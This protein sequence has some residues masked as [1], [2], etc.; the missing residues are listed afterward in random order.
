MLVREDPTAPPPTR[1]T[2]LRPILVAPIALILD[3][4]GLTLALALALALT[5]LLSMA[6][7][8]LLPTRLLHLPLVMSL[9][10]TL[11]L[12]FMQPSL[13]VEIMVFVTS[14]GVPTCATCST[15]VTV[16]DPPFTAGTYTTTVTSN[17]T[18]PV[19]STGT[20]SCATCSVPITVYE[21]PFSAA[22]YTT[23][24]TT[25]MSV[26][27]TTTGTATCATCSIP[28]TVYEPSFTAGTYTTTVTT[29]VTMRMT[30]T[31]TAPCA[32]CSVPVT[33]Y[34]PPTT[35]GTYTTT[36]TADVTAPVTSTGKPSCVTCSTPVT[37]FDPPATTA[38]IFT[39][40]GEQNVTA[41]TTVTK[42]V[43]SS[44]NTVVVQTP[45]CTPGLKWAFY[46][47]TRSP[48]ANTSFPGKIPINTVA[49]DPSSN[50]NSPYGSRYFDVST[51][52][53][54]QSPNVLGTTLL[55]GINARG[56][57]QN[58]PTPLYGDTTV[59]FDRE[60]DVVQQ[61][62]YF[63]PSQSGTYTFNMSSVDD[64]AYLWLG[65][66]AVTGYNN[67]NAAVYSEASFTYIPGQ[68]WRAYTY[69]ATAG[70][71]VP[72]RIMGANAQGFWDYDLVITDPTQAVVS[73]WTQN[74]TNY[75]LVTGC[76]NSTNATPFSF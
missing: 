5:P 8:H 66:A 68:H 57:A 53:R 63:H 55:T 70:S 56:S 67:D 76:T 72:I 18:R 1:T 13:L 47:F 69:T 50:P 71:Y 73:S 37:V 7:A 11:P 29:N 21:P 39:T 34:D 23:T 49:E 42:Y 31:G 45:L 35:A 28:V 9:P 51:I 48:T 38:T 26:P 59:P 3:L 40:Q 64:L 32:T 30:F 61:I 25:D 65:N 52:M 75:Q 33:V 12:I 27:V 60:D 17:F 2:A 58:N 19:T 24:V 74:V 43:G 41:T 15:P 62:G 14:T 44:T 36:I 10:P 6:P 20:P 46:N 22:T 54:G 4:T 16:Y